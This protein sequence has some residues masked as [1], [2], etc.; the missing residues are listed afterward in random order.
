MYKE[1]LPKKWP[2]KLLNNLQKKGPK[3][4]KEKLPKKWPQKATK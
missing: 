1:K 4:Y 2:K 3:M